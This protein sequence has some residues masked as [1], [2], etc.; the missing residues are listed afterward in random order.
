MSPDAAPIVTAV[1]ATKAKAVGGGPYRVSGWAKCGP[2]SQ[3]GGSL[4]ITF[5][6]RD[7]DYKLCGEAWQTQR[8]K[9]MHVPV[10]PGDGHPF[11]VDVMAMP[12]TEWISLILA[13]RG[14]G[15]LYVDD[16][17]LV[18]TEADPHVRVIPASTGLLDGTVAVGSGELFCGGMWARNDSGRE[19]KSPR[20]EFDLP[21]GVRLVPP[22]RRKAEG[23]RE[24]KATAHGRER[25]RASIPWR[26]RRILMFKSFPSGISEL[27]CL[28]ADLPPRDEPYRARARVTGEG[29]EGPWREFRLK[30]LPRIEP[31]APPRRVHLAGTVVRDLEGDA[32]RDFVAAIRRWG[33]NCGMCAYETDDLRKALAESD[34]YM[35]S[36]DWF[37]R[38]NF[39]LMHQKRT[40]ALV[41]K[42]GWWVGRDGGPWGMCP[43]YIAQGHATDSI[44]KPYYRK[45]F[46]DHDLYDSWCTN[47]EPNLWIWKGCF[48]ARCKK[49]FA[50]FAGVPEADVLPLEGKDVVK[51]YPEQW[52]SYRR[53]LNNRLMRLAYKIFGELGKERG[54][55][56][57]ALLAVGPRAIVAATGEMAIQP[58]L[59]ECQGI[60]G[61]S[62]EGV[63]VTQGAKEPTNHLKVAEQTEQIMEAIRTL[64]RSPDFEYYH[65]VLGSFGALVTTPEEME[66]DFLCSVLAR[67]KCL[68]AWA[69]P[70]SYDYRYAHAFARAA[71][72][73]AAHE[74]II[75]EG[76]KSKTVP[77]TPLSATHT[78]EETR[79]HLWAR[80]F[81]KDGT[82]LYAIFN[83]DRNNRVFFALKP[84][85]GAGKNVLHDPVQRIIF[86]PEADAKHGYCLHLGAARAVLLLLEPEGDPNRWAGYDRVECKRIRAAVK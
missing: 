69:L 36:I 66:L 48:C 55:P 61:W 32:A 17:S 6:S 60:S 1:W 41:P 70:V 13:Q 33:M 58:V 65:T 40:R 47:W 2:L 80:S 86:T 7:K 25:L 50:E 63:N 43:E 46:V 44:I 10:S 28:Y 73:I 11:Q 42:D 34:L 26:T 84:Q 9:T 37:W 85:A 72:V 29:Y 54:R 57:P 20:L 18:K 19:V 74:D 81:A 21:A 27:Y 30:I 77:I 38:N 22:T 76:E 52:Q 68:K 16:L 45:I 53:D 82:R 23:L 59:R 31:A 15:E 83:F 24:A 39:Q 67:P 5:Q 14:P 62:Y 51:K 3:K 75:Y 78:S 56:I 8:S 71:R 35:I 79:K 49:Q 64:N 12:D 4:E